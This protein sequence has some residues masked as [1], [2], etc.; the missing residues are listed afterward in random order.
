MIVRE[1]GR[2]E[3]CGGVSRDTLTAQQET[4]KAIAFLQDQIQKAPDSLPL[5]TVL[6]ET[7][8]R[9][10]RYDMAIDH[11][12]KLPAAAPASEQVHLAIGNVYSLKKDLPTA[13][14][15]FE[16]ARKLGPNDPQAMAQPAGALASSASG[17]PKLWIFI[18]R[19]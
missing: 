16:K 19:L 7:A 15:W 11:H 14:G 12:Q 2:A 4:D 8:I 18:S 10:G 6:A 13:I 5:H 17:V 3:G 9:A 1:P